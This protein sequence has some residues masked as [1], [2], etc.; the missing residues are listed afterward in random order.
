MTYLYKH[1]EVNYECRLNLQLTKKLIK[2]S[3]YVY[4]AFKILN[5]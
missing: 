3:L 5:L 4:M 2:K 1:N